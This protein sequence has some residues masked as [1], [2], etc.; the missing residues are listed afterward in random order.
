[1][2]HAVVE[3]VGASAGLTLAVLLLLLRRYRDDTHYLWTA[4]AL[5]GMG[6]LDLFHAAVGPGVAFVW[7]RSIATLVGGTLFTLVWLPERARRGAR[8]L[9]AVVLCCATLTGVLSVAGE[10]NLPLMVTI[11]GFTLA[12]R[13]MNVGGGLGFVLAAIWFLEAYRRQRRWD[14]WLFAT[15]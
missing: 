12:A 8:F 14:E 11:N 6:T 2:L 3:A 15:F 4:C 9:P 7:L 1:P 13:I 5:T 10:A